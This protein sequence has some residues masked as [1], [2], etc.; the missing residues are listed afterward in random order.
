MKLEELQE[1]LQLNDEQLQLV[2][3]FEQST[4]DRIRT[5][6][7]NR[8][9]E[10]ETKLKELTPTELTDEQKE[11]ASLKQELELTKFNNALKDMGVSNE[12]AKYLKQDINLDEFKTFYDSIKTTPNDFVPNDTNI[13]LG[14]GITKE[15]F[16]KM[17]IAERTELYT[18]N[19]ELYQQLTQN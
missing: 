1:Q 10:A 4:E 18:N 14:G 5:D 15:Q 12:M 9:K 19:A 13:N 2:K 3:K 11:I 16:S 17:S 7:S 8:L 6:Y